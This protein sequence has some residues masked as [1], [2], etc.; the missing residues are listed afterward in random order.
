MIERK[1]IVPKHSKHSKYPN[2]CG[3]QKRNCTVAHLTEI[4]IIHGK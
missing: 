2:W 1:Y 4:D 3:Q